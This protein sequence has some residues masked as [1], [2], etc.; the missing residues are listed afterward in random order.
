VPGP[1]RPI[2]LYFLVDPSPGR[3]R[4]QPPGIARVDG[5]AK[6][7]R[8]LK[9]IRK[10]ILDHL[11]AQGGEPSIVHHSLTERAAGLEFNIPYVQN[12][13]LASDM[14][15][16]CSSLS[17]QGS[18]VQPTTSRVHRTGSSAYARARLISSV[19]CGMVFNDF[20]WCG[21]VTIKIHDRQAR[22]RVVFQD[23]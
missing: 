16:L 2:H 7:G 21:V 10:G 17:C 18:G 12:N 14:A 8:L 13:L 6:E 22:R 23:S 3:S 11:S 20:G 9:R 4:G 5:R 15:W 1:A 19:A